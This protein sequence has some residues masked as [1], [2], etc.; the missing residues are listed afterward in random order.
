MQGFTPCFG[1]GW[2][3]MTCSFTR[4]GMMGRRDAMGN[5]GAQERLRMK[6]GLGEMPRAEMPQLVELQ[7][8]SGEGERVK[9]RFAGDWAG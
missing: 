5:F 8:R 9:R 1:T 3:V 6:A 7:E 2:N 4:V